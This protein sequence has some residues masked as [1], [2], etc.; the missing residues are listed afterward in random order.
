[1]A[2]RLIPTVKVRG[3]TPPSEETVSQLPPVVVPGTTLKVRG[4]P[5]EETDNVCCKV[6]GGT[7]PFCNVK[8][9]WL[10]L[11]PRS[12]LEALPVMVKV[13]GTIRGPLEAPAAVMVTEP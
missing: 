7:A 5:L 11:M 1:M 6:A 10:L 2:A 3:V 13:T 12:D 9:T 8:V 4:D